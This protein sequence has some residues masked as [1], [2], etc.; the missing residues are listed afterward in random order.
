[1]TPRMSLFAMPL[2]NRW[3]LEETT[4]AAKSLRFPRTSSMCASTRKASVSTRVSVRVEF[5]LSALS[6]FGGRA[7]SDPLWRISKAR[8]EMPIEVAQVRKS[9]FKCDIRDALIGARCCQ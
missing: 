5:A 7:S 8:L 4:L 2:Q 9:D 1:V 3:P 6:P